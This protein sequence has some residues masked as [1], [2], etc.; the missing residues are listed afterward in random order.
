MNETGLD[1]TGADKAGAMLQEAMHR[2]QQGDLYEAELL[3]RQTLRL[4]PQN[5]QALRLRGILARERGDMDLSLRLLAE[6][7][8]L[9]PHNPAPRG[10]LA[11]SY[12]AIGELDEAERTLRKA[13][14]VGQPVNNI[15]ANLG[16]LL[17]HRGHIKEAISFYREALVSNQED[18]EIRCNLAKALADSG[19]QEEALRECARAAELS[20]QHPHVLA[21]RGAVLIDAKQF[22]D[23][24][25]ILE[26]AIALDPAD[27][28][29]LVNFALANYEL[30]DVGGACTVLQQAV[31]TNPWNARAVADLA[32]CF[33][34]LDDTIAALDLCESFLRQNPGERL[35]VGAYALALHNAGQ[36]AAAA[37]LTD[38]DKLLRMYELPCPN[39]FADSAA[40]NAALVARV[41]D[42]PS[43]TD[44]PV[45]KSTLGGAQTGELDLSEPG[46]LAALGIALKEAV[47]NAIESYRGAG[48]ADHPLMTPACEDW[49][50]RAW[51]TLLRA[52]GRQTAHMHPLGWL[53]G[54]YYA[55]IPADMET[56]NSE[57]GWLEFGRPPERFFTAG[58][59]AT[60]R[61]RP[62][63]GTLILFPSW[64]WHQTIPF[65]SNAPRISIAF[66]VVPK[67]MLRIL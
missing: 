9:E 54:V 58:E 7:A 5:C 31:S 49:T 12:L 57:A 56:V 32:N 65:E 33:C 14:A 3:Y 15:R 39:E 13:L 52:N 2:H 61:Y 18:V 44:N 35:V 26:Q 38:C 19:Q 30:G 6:A 28:M 27:D 36:A 66:D 11:L 20:G 21:T 62:S 10:E 64:F 40:F 29:A 51:G 37:E 22:A 63:A 60:R 48:L 43:L 67:S 24:R 47:D 41:R 1:D 53:S 46:C 17:Q 4:E 42:D 45:S 23:A 25:P 16:A 8:R 34:A 50:M 55:G 59:P